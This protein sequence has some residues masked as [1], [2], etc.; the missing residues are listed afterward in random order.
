MVQIRSTEL[1]VAC[2]V[3]CGG[4]GGRRE[5]IMNVQVSVVDDESLVRSSACD[6]HGAALGVSES[7]W[8]VLAIFSFVS[9]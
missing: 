8:H 7:K 9:F 6:P 5:H 2:F 3:C 1:F 4:G